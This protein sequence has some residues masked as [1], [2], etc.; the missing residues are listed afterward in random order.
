M[1]KWWHNTVTW[2]DL[3][4]SLIAWLLVSLISLSLVLCGVFWALDALLL[5]PPFISCL[6]C[7]LRSISKPVGADKS[8]PD[9]TIDSCGLV[10]TEFRYHSQYSQYKH[11][12]KNFNI[13]H[14][15]FYLSTKNVISIR[16]SFKGNNFSRLHYTLIKCNE[17][18]FREVF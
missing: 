14:N 17:M 1:E 18:R 7:E 9:V 4:W 12:Y 15:S 11:R 6:L 13:V 10:C 3:L 2:Y 8:L 16:L 5:A